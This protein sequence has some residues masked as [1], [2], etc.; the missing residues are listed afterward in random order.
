MLCSL[1]PALV[2]QAIPEPSS[3]QAVWSVFY[4]QSSL[5]TSKGEGRVSLT[6]HC[7]YLGYPTR[8]NLPPQACLENDQM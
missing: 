6:T 1:S 8:S 5:G 7:L 4:S 3:P 2:Q